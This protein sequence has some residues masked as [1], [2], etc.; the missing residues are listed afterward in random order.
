MPMLCVSILV[1]AHRSSSRFMFLSHINVFLFPSLPA[2]LSKIQKLSISLGE[3]KKRKLWYIYT[4]EYY[5]A[6]K[7]KKS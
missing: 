3:D 7:M 1:G 4:M 5:L 2:P 6:V